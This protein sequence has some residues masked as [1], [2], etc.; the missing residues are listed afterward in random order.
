VV[1]ACFDDAP[2][3]IGASVL[4]VPVVGPIAEVGHSGCTQ[5]ICA[6]G[7]NVARKRVVEQHDL[8][9]VRA[10]HPF[11]WVHPEVDIGVGTFI[12]AGAIVQPG[13]RIGAHVILNTG[14]R[15]DHHSSVGDFAH[16][17]GAGLSGGSSVGEGCFVGAR[18]VL[19]PGV[20]AG[21]WSVIGAGAVVTRDVEAG[22]TVAGVP[23][24]PCVRHVA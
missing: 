24:R 11:T 15:A 4:G 3:R 10:I 8:D 7:D 18:G 2:H 14:A 12:G 19:L 5:A 17:A 21:D 13:A 9:W 23:A 22:L 16:L 1:A 20:Q 6:I